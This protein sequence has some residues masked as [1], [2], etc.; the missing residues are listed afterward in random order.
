MHPN[1]KMVNYARAVSGPI[2]PTNN[3]PKNE[4]LKISDRME[5]DSKTWGQKA[6]V[7]SHKGRGYL[8]DLSSGFTEWSG[9]MGGP[10]YE[11]F[12]SHKAVSYIDLEQIESNLESS[13]Y[14][15]KESRRRRLV[16][17]RGGMNEEEEMRRQLKGEFESVTVERVQHLYK[18][19][20][21]MNAE[22]SK[23]NENTLEI[24]RADWFISCSIRLGGVSDL[25]FAVVDVSKCDVYCAY[26]AEHFLH[27]CQSLKLQNMPRE[28]ILVKAYNLT[29]RI[30]IKHPLVQ[31]AKQ[32]NG[33]VYLEG[34]IG[35][36]CDKSI[37]DNVFV[38]KV[39]IGVDCDKII[40]VYRSCSHI[41]NI[42]TL[43]LV[44]RDNEFV[45]MAFEKTEGGAVEYIR[46]R[47]VLRSLFHNSRPMKILRN[48]VYALLQLQKNGIIHGNVAPQNVLIRQGPGND[49][50]IKLC[51]LGKSIKI[52]ASERDNPIYLDRNPA[53]IA[54]KR[55]LART[56]LSILT[57]GKHK[58]DDTCTHAY[59]DSGW[60]TKR[61]K[62]EY[63]E[64]LKE[65]GEDVGD[66][67]MKLMDPKSSINLKMAYLHFC[68]WD[69]NTKLDFICAISDL[70]FNKKLP[71]ANHLGSQVFG[72]EWK[73]KL[74]DDEWLQKM[75]DAAFTAPE[76]EKDATIP[77][78]KKR[79]PVYNIE[80]L[81]D[82]IRLFRN[83]RNHPPEAIV[84]THTPV[85]LM[86]F[87]SS[88]FP[89]LM[90]V[91]YNHF[92]KHAMG[93]ELYLTFHEEV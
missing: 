42:V 49:C 12:K 89:K 55:Q 92:I 38:K 65:V 21:P 58:Y 90:R 39:P 8:V 14:Q 62:P 86:R 73:S 37:E 74:N 44:E 84:K 48:L 66:L 24:K 61:A 32:T 50:F 54:Q 36:D 43:R 6:M 46:D 64:D 17:P 80:K 56:M 2:R 10:T 53:Y 23:G 30:Q 27:I 70:L 34:T 79:D 85:R 7:I 91:L 13:L 51:G 5:T 45:Y 4:R 35:V 11:R 60:Q 26:S 75:E 67:C 78:K 9:D 29:R 15:Y 88:N 18:V 76:K 31:L 72:K 63:D 3:I 20:L 16:I 68:F 25:H 93:S 47:V 52:L 40:E 33:V 82:L 19:V 1:N 69:L 71:P 57:Y 41:A 22:S 87:I 28:G 59:A 77:N 83:S 81:H